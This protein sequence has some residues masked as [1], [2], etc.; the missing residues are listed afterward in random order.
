MNDAGVSEWSE[1]ASATVLHFPTRPR[2]L[3]ATNGNL[4]LLVTFERPINTGTGTVRIWPLLWYE[5]EIT[6]HPYTCPEDANR[7]RTLQVANF[8]QLEKNNYTVI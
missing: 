8:S 7:Q 6:P 1:I 4:S 5:L 2:N 3:N